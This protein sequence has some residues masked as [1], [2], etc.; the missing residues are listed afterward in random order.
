MSDYRRPGVYLEE[1]LQT[2]PTQSGSVSAVG[3]FVGVAPKGDA[4]TAVRVDS[5]SD[6]VQQ[7]GG[8]DQ[9]PA[10]DGTIASNLL[11]YLPY[12]VFSYYQ[13]SDRAAY[14]IRIL[15]SA[16]NAQVRRPRWR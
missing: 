12:A 13:N 10:K 15:P 9:V 16:T 2:Q 1:R 8:F 14:I 7:F 6:Y 4:F 3:V 11:S 5:W